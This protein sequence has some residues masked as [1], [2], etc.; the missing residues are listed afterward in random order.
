VRDDYLRHAAE[1]RDGDA[2]TADH[3]HILAQLDRAPGEA[4][5]N[6]RFQQALVRPGQFMPVDNRDRQ[7][8]LGFLFE[9]VNS[10]A[11]RGAERDYRAKARRDGCGTARGTTGGNPPA[12]VLYQQVCELI[13]CQVWVLGSEAFDALAYRRFSIPNC[14]CQRSKNS[15]ELRRQPVGVHRPQ[16]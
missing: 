11:G 14:G 6:Q 15:P 13:T 3:E 10:L 2:L 7:H 4:D 1:G 9:R 12:R 16:R 8:E 5:H